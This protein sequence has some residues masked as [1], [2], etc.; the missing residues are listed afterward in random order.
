MSTRR[1]DE[2]EAEMIKD[3]EPDEESTKD[4]VGGAYEAYLSIH[5]TKQ[6]SFKPPTNPPPSVPG[7]QN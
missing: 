3:L 4:V 5:G 1:G 6:G 2:A 7:P